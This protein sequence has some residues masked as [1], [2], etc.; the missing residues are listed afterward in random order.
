MVCIGWYRVYG[1][2]RGPGPEH[3]CT[4]DRILT[5]PTLL[6][7]LIGGLE[8]Q[9]WPRYHYPGPPK[10]YTIYHILCTIY[11]LGHIVTWTPKVC[12]TMAL[13][14]CYNYP[15]RPPSP[16]HEAEDD[17]RNA[18]TASGLQFWATLNQEWSTLG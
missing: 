14:P 11:S 3:N 8:L 4:C 15:G 18:W 10:A 13:W 16:E 12:K 6:K 7:G 1:I 2:C 17:S 5:W 9:L